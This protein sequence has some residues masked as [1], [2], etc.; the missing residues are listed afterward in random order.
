M[1]LKA[2]GLAGSALAAVL[3]FKLEDVTGGGAAQ[4]WSGKLGS[5]SSVDLGL[6]RV[7]REPRRTGFTL[8][9]PAASDEASLQGASASLTFQWHGTAQEERSV[10]GPGLI[11]LLLDG[12]GRVRARRWASRRPASPTS[13]QNP[14]TVIRRHRLPRPERRRERGRQGRGRHRQATCGQAA[15]TAS[16]RTSPSPATPRAKPPRSKPTSRRSP[17]G[18]RR[19][20]STAGSYSGG[21]SHLQ[22]PQRPAESRQRGQRRDEVLRADARS[23]APATRA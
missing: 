3:D 18:R 4:K 21:R 19:S 23:T 20:R 17:R 12:P 15:T 13:T 16:T 22:L 5:F 2:S 14:Q 7:R 6:V 10:S 9:W 1:T 11:G 8:S